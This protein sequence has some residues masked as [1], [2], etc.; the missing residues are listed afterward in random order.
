M[1]LKIKYRL[2]QD[3]RYSLPKDFKATKVWSL[4]QSILELLYNKFAENTIT[5]FTLF[6]AENRF[7][8]AADPKAFRGQALQGR[9]ELCT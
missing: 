5:L 6:N 9:D 8:D 3:R 1:A 4:V 2:S 7:A